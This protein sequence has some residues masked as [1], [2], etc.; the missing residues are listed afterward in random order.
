MRG[1]L[2]LQAGKGEEAVREFRALLSTDSS[3]DDRGKALCG[4][5]RAMEKVLPGP[6]AASACEEAAKATQRRD[7]TPCPCTK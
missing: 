2:L 6:E 3:V 7:G 5:A 4:L 1:D